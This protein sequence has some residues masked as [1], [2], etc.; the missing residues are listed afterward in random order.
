MITP[1]KN[2]RAVFGAEGI[3]LSDISDRDI[4]DK[5]YLIH[6]SSDQFVMAKKIAEEFN[7]SFYYIDENGERKAIKQWSRMGN[8]GKKIY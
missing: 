2:E 7:L 3:V 8:N 1:L 6:S 5:T 4:S